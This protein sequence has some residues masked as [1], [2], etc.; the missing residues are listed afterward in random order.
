MGRAILA[1]TDRVV[2]E[3]VDDGKLGKRGQ[4]DRRTR[5]IA[6]DEEC[7]S[8]RPKNTVIGKPVENATHGVL[9]YAEEQVAPTA[10]LRVKIPAVLY[11]VE[12]RPMEVGAAGDDERHR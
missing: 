1:Y 5:V 11:V 9:A 10:I 12:R 3:D 2:C 4:T 7:R 6:K 8:A